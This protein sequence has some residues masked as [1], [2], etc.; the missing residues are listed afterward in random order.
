MGVAP[1]HDQVFLDFVR[2]SDDALDTNDENVDQSFNL[3]CS[4]KSDSDHITECFC[5]DW[6]YVSA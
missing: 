3:D 6:V 2:L 4:M 5:D 1:T